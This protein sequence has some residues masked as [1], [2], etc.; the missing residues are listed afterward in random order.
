[1]GQDAVLPGH[2]VGLPPPRLRSAAPRRPAR[3]PPPAGSALQLFPLRNGS[4]RTARELR[5]PILLDRRAD[6][7]RSQ[8]LP[9][10]VCFPRLRR[11]PGRLPGYHRLL[12]LRVDGVRSA[13]GFQHVLGGGS[14]AADPRDRRRQ[15]R[16]RDPSVVLGILVSGHR[17]HG[18]G[19]SDQLQGA[20]QAA[21]LQDRC[22]SGMLFLFPISIAVL[23]PAIT[24]VL[25]RC[26]IDH[27]CFRNYRSL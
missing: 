10:P 8:I 21:R 2:H 14:A 1:M 6:R 12:Q 20:A 7:F 26:R 25:D 22:R 16:C 11:E 4:Q 9:Y 15:G 17:S 23:G 19:L 18:G 27:V 24:R 3:P 5:L 13:Q